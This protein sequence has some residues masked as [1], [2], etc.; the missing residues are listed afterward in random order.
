MPGTGRS[1]NIK[2]EPVKAAGVL[3]KIVQGIEE[4]AG[5]AIFYAFIGMPG[6]GCIFPPPCSTPFMQIF[7]Q[8]HN[9]SLASI[10]LASSGAPGSMPHHRKFLEYDGFGINRRILAACH[11]HQMVPSYKGA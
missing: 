3:L 10:G 4:S 8:A 11:W 5:I 1:K 9:G 7:F 2:S 6:N